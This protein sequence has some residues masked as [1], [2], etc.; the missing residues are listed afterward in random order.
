MVG[1]VKSPLVKELGS[2]GPIVRPRDVSANLLVVDG[3]AYSG[4]IAEEA[5]LRRGWRAGK[6]LLIL[7]ADEGDL[8]GDLKATQ[9]GPSGRLARQAFLRQVGFAFREELPVPPHHRQR[10]SDRGAKAQTASSFQ[11][12]PFP[13][14]KMYTEDLTAC[15][16]LGVED[17]PV[18]STFRSSPLTDCQGL[19]GVGIPQETATLELADTITVLGSGS[20]GGQSPAIAYIVF[21]GNGNSSV[22]SFGTFEVENDLTTTLYASGYANPQHQRAVGL[23]LDQGTPILVSAQPANAAGEEEVESGVDFEIGVTPEG[24][25][26]SFTYSTETSTSIQGWTVTQSLGGGSSPGEGPI[27]WSY[28]EQLDANQNDMAAIYSMLFASNWSFEND[29]GV[30]T[31]SALAASLVQSAPMVVWST[32]E[33]AGSQQATVTS[34]VT[35]ANTFWFRQDPLIGT[36]S[37]SWYLGSS[38]ADGSYNSELVISTDGSVVISLTDLWNQMGYLSSVSIPT[39]VS[40]GAQLPV[41]VKLDHPAPQAGMPLLVTS[42]APGIIPGQTLLVPAG[43]ASFSF[44]IPVASGESGEVTLTFSV[45]GLTMTETTTVE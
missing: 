14:M 20:Y 26:G 8:K 7:D 31:P 35:S 29:F 22:Q 28:Q 4:T 13:I 23:A 11:I 43:N 45:N 37:D 6:G 34:Q 38:L 33:S 42:S 30:Y 17:L 41:A 32:T 9:N 1:P 21:A 2:L 12:G 40:S 24:P 19:P 3:D 15:V 39:T 25:E 36:S 18:R 10:A 5:L 27:N 44:Q 16:V